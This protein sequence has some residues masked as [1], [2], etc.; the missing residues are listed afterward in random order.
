MATMQDIETW[1]GRT[2]VDRDGDKIGKIEDIYLDRSSGEPEWV[3][4]KTGLFGTNVSFVPIH[5]ADTSGDDAARAR[6]RRTRSRTPRTSTPTASSRPRRSAASTSTTAAATTSAARTRGLPRTARRD[7]RDRRAATPP[8]R[9][10]TT[11]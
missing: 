3:A 8:A 5:D 6:T 7:E 2:L 10:P 9:R 11:R 1:R 4:V